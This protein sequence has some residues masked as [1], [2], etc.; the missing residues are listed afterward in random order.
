MRFA[1]VVTA[2]GNVVVLQNLVI[3]YSLVVGSRAKPVSLSYH[4]T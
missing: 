1:G 3:L 4:A 2:T